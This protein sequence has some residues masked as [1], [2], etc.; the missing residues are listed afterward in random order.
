MKRSSIVADGHVA[1]LIYARQ[2]E[3]RMKKKDISR[4]LYLHSL[5]HLSMQGLRKA[6]RHSLRIA[7]AFSVKVGPCKPAALARFSVK[8]RPWES[9]V[10]ALLPQPE[11]EIQDRGPRGQ[12]HCKNRRPWQDSHLQ[13]WLSDGTHRAHRSQDG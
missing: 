12:L 2:K 4:Q 7:R 13:E 5:S 3:Q 8:V 6:I 11:P 9:V 10:F 1:A